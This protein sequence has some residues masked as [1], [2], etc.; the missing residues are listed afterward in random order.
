MAEPSPEQI[1]ARSGPRLRTL[2]RDLGERHASWL[3]LFFD[4]VFVLAVA[5]VARVLT[6]HT[7]A[8]GFLKY[9]L[10]FIPVWWGWVGFTFYADRFESEEATYRILMFL[11]MLAV[12]G[13]SLTF[14]DAFTPAGDVPFVVCYVLVR[15]VLAALYLR[16]AYYVPLARAFSLQYPIGL[17]ISSSLLLLS[18]LVEAP[19]RY[20]IWTT[21][22]AVEF[23]TPLLNIRAARTLPIDSAH[24]PE[25]FGLFTIIVLGEAVFGTATGLSGVTWNATTVVTA[26]L[27]FAMAAA[28]WWINFEFVEDSALASNSLLRRFSYIYGHFF[29]VA[30][31]VATGI[32]VEH[33]IKETGEPHLHFSTLALL[34]GGVAVHLTAITVI[35][36]IT[37]I[38]KLIYP[39]V[40]AVAILLFLLYVGQFLPPIAVVAVSLV[41]LIAEVWLESSYV[42]EEPV[43]IV[44]FLM[45]C[46]HVDEMR[47]FTARTGK[48][49]CEECVK[50]NYKWVHLRLCLTC[51]H[52]GCCDSSAYTH[53]TKHFHS[54]GHPIIASLEPQESW[55][56]CY[57]DERFVP[58]TNEVGP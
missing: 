9:V 45:P 42:S 4:L 49:E 22:F 24:V 53:A 10:L 8:A 18:L 31:I 52:V 17:G 41:L 23:I 33:A 47:V 2:G 14:A 1:R 19:L 37:G 58:L 50:N 13:F 21:A 5:Q 30:S 38:C 11:G 54:Q 34:A 16:V 43:E 48:L 15:A 12:I 56:W 26:C 29:I 36:L 20:A 44:P 55:A 39:R 35:R 51:G 28:I 25:R 32:G 27:G 40:M 3:E 7:D 6:G 57:A 46:E